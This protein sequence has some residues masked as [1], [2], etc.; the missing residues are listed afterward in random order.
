MRRVTIGASAAAIAMLL[1]ACSSSYDREQAIEDIQE[2]AGVDRAMAECI[3]DGVEENFS[4]DRLES[5]GDL[6]E[7]EEAV[8]VEITT[9]CLLGG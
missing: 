3:V 6:T 7:E 1:G 4:I 9:E 2:T 5:S 8:L